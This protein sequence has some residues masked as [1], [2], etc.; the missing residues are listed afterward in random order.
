[1]DVPFQNFVILKYDFDRVRTVAP[2]KILVVRERRFKFSAV[3]YCSLPK[4]L[5]RCRRRHGRTA[6]ER[7]ATFD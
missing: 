7:R 1:M 5:G 2:F 4:S 6:A 3:R